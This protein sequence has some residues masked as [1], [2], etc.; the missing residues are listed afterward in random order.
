MHN[1]GAYRKAVLPL[2]TKPGGAERSR[3]EVQRQMLLYCKETKKKYQA[4]YFREQD[5]IVT[6]SRHRS[7]MWQWEDM[8]GDTA[9]QKFDKAWSDLPKKLKNKYMSKS[10]QPRIPIEDHATSIRESGTRH[11]RSNVTKTPTPTKRNALVELEEEAVEQH[12]PHAHNYRKR[13]GN[14]RV[15][16]IEGLAHKIG[17]ALEDGDSI[18]EGFPEDEQEDHG[19]SDGDD[20]EGNHEADEDAA[21]E[22]SEATTVRRRPAAAHGSKALCHEAKAKGAADD[23]ETQFP[24]INLVMNLK[25]EKLAKLKLDQILKL[26]EALEKDIMSLVK[27]PNANGATSLVTQVQQRKKLLDELGLDSPD[28]PSNMVVGEDD[29]DSTDASARVVD[30]V[31]SSMATLLATHESIKSTKV[32]ALKNLAQSISDQTDVLKDAL[33]AAEEFA[34]AQNWV[35]G[36]KAK[37]F[38]TT[39]TSIGHQVVRCKCSS[40]TV[41]EVGA[42]SGTTFDSLRPGRAL[43]T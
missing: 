7:L 8:D 17:V 29:D 35:L 16:M 2:I 32:H 39:S 24:G 27:H 20:E 34:A 12:A 21:A 23:D 36:K 5:L 25:D 33:A 26:K 38:Q 41:S 15:K 18:D 28:L 13:P 30:F 10:Q 43:G 31:T 22:S 1:P 9:D 3:A 6:K 11:S 19:M 40:P 14:K 4:T 42:F 37:Q